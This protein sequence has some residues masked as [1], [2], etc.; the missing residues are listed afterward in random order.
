MPNWTQNTIRAEGPEAALRTFIDAIKGLEEPLDFDRIVPMPALLRSTSS[1]YRSFDGVEHRAWYQ[2]QHRP[3]DNGIEDDARPFT[4][5]EQAALAEIGH[6]DWYSW[7]IQ[8]WGTKWNA[9]HQEV[10]EQRP[11]YFELRFDTAWDMPQ[12]I[13]DKLFEMFPDLEISWSWAHEHD[14]YTMRYSMERDPIISEE[15]EAA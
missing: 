10:L 12:P 14:G 9:C 2:T 7:S 1:G 11:G 13:A 3:F 15:E 8:H 6:T 5:E 4:P